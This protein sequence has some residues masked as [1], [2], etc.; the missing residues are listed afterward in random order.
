MITKM[1]MSSALFAAALFLGFGANAQTKKDNNL[2]DVAPIKNSL[3]YIS[4][5]EPLTFKH[6]AESIK[7]FNLPGGQQYGFNAEAMRQVIPGAVKSQKKFIPAGKNNFKT[8]NM[9]QV[10][11]EALI[12]MLVGS[13][14][15][16]QAQI[17]ALKAEI[18]SL[19]SMS[20][21]PAADNTS[22]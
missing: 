11:M 21:L 7:M 10:D 9:N 4:Q 22:N 17:E 15:E 8:A 13:I 2:T 16:Q 1:K 20:A 6:S 3:S 12:P 14:K 18:Q 5:L 19:K